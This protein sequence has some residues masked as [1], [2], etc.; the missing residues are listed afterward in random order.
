MET[1][2]LVHRLEETFHDAIVSAADEGS[3][4]H[5]LVKVDQLKSVMSYC[6]HD[7]ATRFNVLECMT[8]SD[9]GSEFSVI[10]HLRSGTLAHRLNVKVALARHN[11]VMP[12]MTAFWRA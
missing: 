11:P 3:F 12:S 8:G 10:F 7:P 6:C 1:R 4:P 5:V 9:S 2:E